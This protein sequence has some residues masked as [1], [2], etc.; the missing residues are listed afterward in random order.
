MECLTFTLPNDDRIK[1]FFEIL[2]KYNS[3]NLVIWMTLILKTQFQ[4][5]PMV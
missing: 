1:G 3:E 2:E 5:V 4:L